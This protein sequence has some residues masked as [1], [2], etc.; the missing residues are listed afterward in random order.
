MCVIVCLCAC[1]Q[2]SDHFGS[3]SSS[4]ACHIIFETD[5]LT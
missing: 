1:M 2:M 3:V 5:S 4:I